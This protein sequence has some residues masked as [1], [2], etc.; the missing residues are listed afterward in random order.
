MRL[1][2]RL[3]H[4]V[5]RALVAGYYGL[6]LR[7]LLQLDHLLLKLD[8]L[9]LASLVEPVYVKVLEVRS[10]L[11]KVV[12][13]WAV[14]PATHLWASHVLRYLLIWL[15]ICYRLLRAGNR[16]CIKGSALL[17][18]RQ[19]VAL[20]IQRATCVLTQCLKVILKRRSSLPCGLLDL[21]R[22]FLAVGGLCGGALCFFL[23]KN[24]DCMLS[25]L[26][27]LML[28]E[29]LFADSVV[30]MLFVVVYLDELSDCI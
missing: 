12:V 7:V 5:W 30:L 15:L 19:G 6:E 18:H 25:R 26:S 29:R 11:V 10:R 3:L 1:L 2:C 17:G 8:I 27:F 13:K 9:L 14:K 28:F 16:V 22:L 4:S 21:H 20:V 23:L 24:L